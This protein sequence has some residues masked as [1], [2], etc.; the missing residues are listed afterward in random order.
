MV[1]L[2]ACNE[3]TAVVA[4]FGFF[5]QV[6]V[7]VIH[8]SRALAVKADFLLDQAIGVVIELVGFACLVFDRGQQQARVV[9][10]VVDM[11]AIGIDTTAD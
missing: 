8:V 2:I 6:A 4:V 7:E 5:R 11:A 10:A 3:L 9:V 1:S